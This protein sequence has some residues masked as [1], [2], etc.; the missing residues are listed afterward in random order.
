ML[1]IFVIFL[2]LVPSRFPENI[3]G[4]ALTTTSML[5]EWDPILPGFAHGI[6]LS[7]NLTVRE[8]DNLNHLIVE[9]ALPAY[10]RSYYVEGLTKFTNYTVWV[11]ATNSKGKGPVYKPGHIN[12]TGEDGKV[13]FW[14]CDI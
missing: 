6:I 5:F 1:I 13:V 8:T 7:Y 14:L 12:S 3:R 4:N 2:P 10:E 9:P 11:S